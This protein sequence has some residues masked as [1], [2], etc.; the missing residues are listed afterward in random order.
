MGDKG[1]SLPS[2]CS[3]GPRW[4]Q[5]R[6]CR[7]SPAKPHTVPAQVLGFEATAEQ[8]VSSSLQMCLQPLPSG[9][10]TPNVLCSTRW[11]SGLVIQPACCPPPFPWC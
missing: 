4:W 7:Q 1:L 3:P 11:G 5:C 9:A 10:C 6:G 8:H 2:P